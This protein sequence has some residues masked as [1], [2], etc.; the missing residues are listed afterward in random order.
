MYSF[1]CAALIKNFSC[2]ISLIGTVTVDSNEAYWGSRK[3][4]SE[5]FD[6]KM[7]SLSR[8]FLLIGHR[9]REVLY[10]VFWCPW[11]VNSGCR[12][13][14]KFLYIECCR[15]NY[16]PWC[17]YVDNLSRSPFS[18]RLLR[19]RVSESSG[20]CINNPPWAWQAGN[21]NYGRLWGRLYG[22]S[23]DEPPSVNLLNYATRTGA[24]GSVTPLP[25]RGN[26]KYQSG[27]SAVSQKNQAVFF[28]L[29]TETCKV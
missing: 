20:F 8:L 13:V 26:S 12:R 3:F 18:G 10:K 22:L 25:I 19:T 15:M 6:A 4:C 17:S 5:R 23:S 28:C 24:R 14:V 16:P 1:K 2:T 27:N 7:G 9:G 21:S 29:A 11:S